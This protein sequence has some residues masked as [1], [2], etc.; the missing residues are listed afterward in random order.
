MA[1]STDFKY[2]LSS[3]SDYLGRINKM[4][5]DYDVAFHVASL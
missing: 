1:D 3:A 2:F 4:T 5:S